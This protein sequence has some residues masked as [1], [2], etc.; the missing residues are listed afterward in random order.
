MSMRLKLVLSTL[1][2]FIGGADT[3]FQ[4]HSGPGV[5]ITTALWWVGMVLAGLVPV[6]AY[7]V[8]LGQKGPWDDKPN[9][10]RA[11]ATPQG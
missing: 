7:Y 2:L 6:G 1:G 8:G 10:D 4:L 9:R 5:N 11:G 3:Y